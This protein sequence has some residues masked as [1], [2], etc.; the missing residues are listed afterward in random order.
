MDKAETTVYYLCGSRKV[1]KTLYSQLPATI[2]TMTLLLLATSIIG[3]KKG[4]VKDV[5]FPFNKPVPCLFSHPDFLLH[6]TATMFSFPLNWFSQARKETIFFFARV[7][8]YTQQ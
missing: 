6:L 5:V 7:Q 1:E 8:L 2:A 3:V 4:F